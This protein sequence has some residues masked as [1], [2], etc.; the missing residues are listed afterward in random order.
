MK[1]ENFVALGMPS[2]ALK[3]RA[4]RHFEWKQTSNKITDAYSY[5]N[6]LQN[7]EFFICIPDAR[8]G[9]EK[10][11]YQKFEHVPID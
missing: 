4:I 7:W 2:V 11:V 6:L 8:N 3:I 5:G 10:Y 1:V 9:T